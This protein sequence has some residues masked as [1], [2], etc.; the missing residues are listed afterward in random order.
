MFVCMYKGMH[1]HT[2][3]CVCLMCVRNLI[4]NRVPVA[5][6]GLIVQIRKSENAQRPAA[7]NG[8][9]AIACVST[10]IKEKN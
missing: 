7:H 4:N 10:K 1:A 2:F 5:K 3:V 9:I 8:L 6:A